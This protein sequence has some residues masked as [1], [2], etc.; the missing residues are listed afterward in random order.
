MLL[1]D[2]AKMKIL[3]TCKLIGC[4][5]TYHKGGIAYANVV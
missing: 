3:P 4:A 1:Q 5:E 2:M